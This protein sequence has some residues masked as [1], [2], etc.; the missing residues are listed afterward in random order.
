MRYLTT[1]SAPV[2]VRPAGTTT[3]TA[4]DVVSTDPGTILLF[5]V[6]VGSAG[7]GAGIVRYAMV[8][9]SG[10]GIVGCTF[11]LHLFNAAPTAIK[12]N[13][14]WE[15]VWASRLTHLGYVDLVMTTEGGTNETPTG[16][17]ACEIPFH[18]A[19][20]TAAGIY[21][22]LCAEGAYPPYTLEQFLVQIR[23]EAFV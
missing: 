17:A 11:R 12:D 4:G 18:L 5:P 14:P 2:I 13:D 19:S 22:V 9:K 23:V 3:Y 1:Y 10:T 15:L 16:Q 21:G 20:A 7:S 8:K 6:K